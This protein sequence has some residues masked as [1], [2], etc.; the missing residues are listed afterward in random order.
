MIE[1]Q[2]Y[3]GTDITLRKTGINLRN[4]VHACGE[5]FYG[6]RM[7]VHVN[8][9]KRIQ[10]VSN[11]LATYAIV[12]EAYV[13]VFETCVIC[14]KCIELLAH[15]G[16]R[17]SVHGSYDTQRFDELLQILSKIHRW[18]RGY[19]CYSGNVM[20]CCSTIGVIDPAPGA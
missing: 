2:L 15:V 11:V 4:K 7:P 19:T 8:V 20:D 17:I 13:I 5:R 3:N 1:I 18:G 6:R 12:L 10:C 16:K 14:L 9:S